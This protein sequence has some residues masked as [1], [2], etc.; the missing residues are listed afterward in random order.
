L[1]VLSAILDL[2]ESDPYV[3]EG[4]WETPGNGARVKE[5]ESEVKPVTD[6]NSSS[7]QGVVLPLPESPRWLILKGRE[8]EALQVLSAILDLDESERR[9]VQ[10]GGSGGFHP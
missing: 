4:D 5:G 6:R 8:L 2:D 3:L 1:Q 9:Q 10:H 7:N